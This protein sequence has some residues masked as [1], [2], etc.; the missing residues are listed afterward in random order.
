MSI[1]AQILLLD[2]EYGR[3]KVRIAG[4]SSGT[5]LDD[6][7]MQDDGGGASG[8]PDERLPFY[9]KRLEAGKCEAIAIIAG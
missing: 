3:E 9:P 6:R 7:S 5:G 1:D 8:A 4:G 2:V